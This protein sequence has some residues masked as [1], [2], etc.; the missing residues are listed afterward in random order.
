MK[1]ELYDEALKYLT[2]RYNLSPDAYSAKWLGI[3]NLS[4]QNDDKAIEYLKTSLSFIANDEQVL[5]NL[6]GA[7][8]R[9]KNYELAL[10]NVKQALQINPNY[11]AALSLKSQLEKALQTSR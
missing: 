2:A 1:K 9:K 4:K 10:E 11:T 6:A 5:Y 3:I 8:S 7:Y